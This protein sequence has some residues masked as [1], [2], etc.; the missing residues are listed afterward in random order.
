MYYFDLDK[1]EDAKVI[2]PK[3]SVDLNK[4]ICKVV[5]IGENNF[6]FFDHDLSRFFCFDTE[7][8]SFTKTIVRFVTPSP[9]TNYTIHPLK[10]GR[11]IIIGGMHEDQCYNEVHFLIPFKYD[12]QK[13]YTSSRLDIYG[14]VEGSYNGHASI[15]LENSHLLISGGSNSA[16]DPFRSSDYKKFEEEIPKRIKIL[17]IF[18]SYK[19]VHPTGSIN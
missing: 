17:N 1:K 19:W 13:H 2:F 12:S 15:V 6:A 4:S 8:E 14:S 18:M 11:I 7:T 10:D 16:Y 9:R 3:G 5:S